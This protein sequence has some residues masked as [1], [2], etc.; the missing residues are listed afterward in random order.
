MIDEED[1]DQSDPRIQELLDMIEAGLHRKSDDAAFDFIN[2]ILDDAANSVRG[3]CYELKHFVS[4]DKPYPC[5]ECEAIMKRI[6]Y[7]KS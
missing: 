4:N 3:R 1:E 5:R 7:G 6:R 2:N